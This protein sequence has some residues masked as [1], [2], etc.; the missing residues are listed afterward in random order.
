MTAAQVAIAL[1]PT[2]ETLGRRVAELSDLLHTLTTE[3]AI[4][5]LLRAGRKS[6]TLMT[7][8]DVGV[9]PE[10]GYGH[11]DPPPNTATS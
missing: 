2:K 4:L 6:P 11:T 10:Q 1:N 9:A 3:L 7:P 8:G 5:P